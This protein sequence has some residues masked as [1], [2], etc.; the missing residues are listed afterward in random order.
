MQ[1]KGEDK[2]LTKE[3]LQDVVTLVSER[4]EKDLKS[5]LNKKEYLISEIL[6]DYWEAV[7]TDGTYPKRFK[8]SV[9]RNDI[10][11]LTWVTTKSDNN[12]L[13]LIVA[14]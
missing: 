10:Q 11:Y 14:P 8:K 6:N 4:I 12:E 5:G 7:K 9:K 1:E 3:E 2:F 13:Y